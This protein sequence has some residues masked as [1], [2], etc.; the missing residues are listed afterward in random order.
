MTEE[1][2]I[3]QIFENEY[4]PEAAGWCN[5]RGDCHITE[6]ENNDDIR[7]FKI[8]E[9]PQPGAKELK[10]RAIDAI[11]SQLNELDLKSIR[12][13]RANETAYLEQYES[14]AVALR[15]QLKELGVTDD[16]QLS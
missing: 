1:F 8:V 6:M 14:Q 2:Y 13:L 12:A 4:P 15:Q 3:G 5:E 11:K 10:A 16:S 7:R 9:N